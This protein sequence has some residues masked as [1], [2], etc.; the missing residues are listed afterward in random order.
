MSQKQKAAWPCS[1][2]SKQKKQGFI[3][4]TYAGNKESQGNRKQQE[5]FSDIGNHMKKW[6]K[7]YCRLETHLFTQ[8]AVI[9][10]LNHKPVV[11]IIPGFQTHVG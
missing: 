4:A 9:K 11:K 6:C 3:F 1:V 10:K 8:E 7:K 2:L 5:H